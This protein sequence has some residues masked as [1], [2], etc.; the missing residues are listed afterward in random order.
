[1]KITVTGCA[2]PLMA[3]A[4]LTACNKEKSTDAEL[5]EVAGEVAQAIADARPERIA[6]LTSYP[7]ERPYPLRN[8][9]DSAS[10]MEYYPIMFDDSLRRVFQNI[11]PSD[12]SEAGWRGWTVD[13]GQYIWIDGGLYAVNYLSAA[14]RALR[15]ILAHD[16]IRSLAPD[17]RKDWTPVFCLVDVNDGTLYRVDMSLE[18]DAT[19]DDELYLPDENPANNDRVYRLMQY[20]AGYR[21]N[22]QPARI[23]KGR[24]ELDGTAQSRT[25]VFEQG[26]SIRVEYLYDRMS[27]DDVPT[28][29]WQHPDG[30]ET[31]NEVAPAY[32]RDYTTLRN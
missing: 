29:V 18:G 20:P 27:D 16:E 31:G 6:A 1:M 26:D 21:L 17:L 13:R 28:I 11:Q 22:G 19:H 10:L 14:E 23:M 2:L 25:Y 4:V 3:L 5:P 9:A 8:I 24:M 7:L 15:E 30:T 32:W 12:W